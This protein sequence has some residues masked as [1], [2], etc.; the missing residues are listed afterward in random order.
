MGTHARAT[1]SSP[2]RCGVLIAAALAAANTS[3]P[4]ASAQS[5]FEGLGDL[6]GGV[7]ESRAQGVSADGS[8]VVGISISASGVE[9]FRWVEN[10]NPKMV[11]LGDLPGRTFRSQ[12]WA[13][14][15]NGAVVTGQSD[16]SNNFKAYRWTIGSG[17]MAEISGIVPPPD[18]ACCG[19]G[20]SGDGATVVG[21]SNN[22][23]DP[24]TKAFA[25]TP[26]GGVVDLGNLPGGRNPDIAFGVSGDGSVIVGSGTRADGNTEAFRWTAATG[27]VGLG[28][29]PGGPFYSE[30]RA[31]SLDG[32]IVVGVSEGTTGR[33]AFKWTA[34]TGMVSLSD[35]PAGHV[36]SEAVSVS[37]DGSIVVGDGYG[38]DGSGA[39]MWTAA[40]G[41]VSVRS[42]LVANGA[43]IPVSWTLY[44]S[45]G[46]SAEGCT[47]IGRGFGP[48]GTEGWIARLD[49]DGDGLL[50]CWEREHGGIDGD[51]DGLPDLNLWDLGARENFK[52]IFVEVD[53]MSGRVPTGGVLGFPTV[54]EAVADAFINSPAT[55]P[56][57]PDG[58]IPTG[59]L[60][61][62]MLDDI[63]IPLAPFPGGFTQFNVHKAA[64]FGTAAE[65]PP[66]PDTVKILAAKRK[67]F[68]YCI[69]ADTVGAGTTSGLAEFGGNDFL[70]S[71][72]G[73]RTP[74]GTPE[75]Q[76]ATFMHEFGHTLGLVHGGGQNDP[77]PAKD[78]RYNYKPNYYSLMN[79]MWQ[80]HRNYA[81]WRLD[82]SHDAL[83]PLDENDLDEPAGLAIDPA[84]DVQIGPP[85]AATL[86][87]EPGGPPG[88]G[89]DWDRDGAFMGAGLMLDINYIRPDADGNGV[90]NAADTSPG[91]TLMGHND[92]ANLD[93]NFRDSAD[94]NDGVNSNTTADAEI[95]QEADD[96]L[97]SL[98]PP[99]CP[100]DFDNNGL[101]EVPDLFTFLS[102]WFAGD[103]AAY[104][105]GG[106]PGVP[107]IFAFLSAWFTGCP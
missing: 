90:V 85:P 11:G 42:A 99:T 84:V 103:P 21:W 24:T 36:F 27:M 40:T 41:A 81:G 70:V 98:G 71:L 69:F 77:N 56:Q 37:A 96:F 83:D 35:V 12:A 88:L 64:W 17:S 95:D 22:P 75:Q 76:A 2:A 100:A 50:D 55:N 74:G 62:A 32:T 73:W 34:A 102:A 19:F 44:S 58:T 16:G 79:Y 31:V 54:L 9:A 92:W 93:Y 72:G 28:D 7:F 53:A 52:D 1:S 66:N 47:I 38:P 39:Y 43:D 46:V 86:L 63:G 13:V 48:R 106:T 18:A 29:L 91:D 8:V 107:A 3:T 82:Y 30:A 57:R 4:V 67:A 97:W 89:V 33:Q 6:P 101:V 26:I 94:F 80:M 15:A 10:G 49:R 25:F 78:H 104:E 51:N 45:T 105:F 59:I 61:H 68:R 23:S 87:R 60:L 5:A 20:V 14:N 65:R